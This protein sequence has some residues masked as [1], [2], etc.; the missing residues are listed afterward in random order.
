M[1]L[2]TDLLFATLAKQLRELRSA[3]T[4]LA[5][6]PGP[7]GD[8]G[9]RGPVGDTG[10]RGAQGVA[11]RAG[12][13]G[14][15]GDI[16][17]QGPQGDRGPQGPKGE[18]GEKGD[19][20]PKGDQGAPGPMPDHQWSGSRLRFQKPGGGWGQFKD[21]KG[22]GAL[23]VAGGGGSGDTH[24]HGVDLDTLPVASNVIVPSAIV[25]QQEG[26][27]VRATWAQ[28]IELLRSTEYGI[29]GG[30]ASSVFMPAEAVDG[31]GA[32]G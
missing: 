6:E 12:A 18:K 31:G 9:E 8:V 7:K 15:V 13:R 20:G 16:G 5:R 24:V 1:S 2:T 3:F 4:Q 30:S 23:I 14:P 19:Q 22:E 28:F 21:L 27:W 29:D 26:V 32:N 25:L 17:P 10:E 11:G